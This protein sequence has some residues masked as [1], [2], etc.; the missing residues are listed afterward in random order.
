M[1]ESKAKSSVDD[2]V[3]PIDLGKKKGESADTRKS[4][5][6]E[7]KKSGTDKTKRAVALPQRESDSSV[8]KRPAARAAKVTVSE[9]KANSSDGASKEK[10]PTSKPTKK[11]SSGAKAKQSASSGA[12]KG[13]RSQAK[14]RE[15]EVLA[16]KAKSARPRYAF[17]VPRF[18]RSGSQSEAYAVSVVHEL[19][20]RGNEVLVV[21]GNGGESEDEHVTV[22]R[23]NPLIMGRK[24]IKTFKPRH[25]IDWGY[26]IPAEFRHVDSPYE[27]DLRHGIG[28]CKGLT[29]LIKHIQFRFSRQHRSRIHKQRALMRVS[30]AQF[31]AQSDLVAEDLQGA[32]VDAARIH[33][34]PY[35]VDLDRFSP[36][37]NGTAAK[38]F[39]A[40]HGFTDDEVIFLC[41][42][43]D[44]DLV[45]IQS[46]RAVFTL[47]HQKNPHVRLLHMGTVDPGWKDTWF[48]HISRPEQP[49]AVYAAAD[50][51]VHPAVHDSAAP[52]VIQAMA[53]ALPVV[54]TDNIGS[55][56]FVKDSGGALFVPSRGA[57]SEKSWIEAVEQLADNAAKRKQLGQA[58]R[59]A[60][61]QR[62]LT[63]FVD[64]LEIILNRSPQS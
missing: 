27:Q 19:A 15:S 14:K 44:P 17:V 32:G 3:K 34:L 45:D 61:A 46:L 50:A 55:L 2:T 29:R 54:T 49:E 5:S 42:T 43:D 48:V 62:T 10:A 20:R 52:V 58:G 47:V 41:V 37:N 6:S 16:E 23:A 59:N 57:Q 18:S 21:T 64:Q 63:N 9:D 38:S 51:L 39:R 25:I 30:K 26:N 60:A 11:S 28:A 8:S 35:G 56:Q 12:S 24:A 4:A 22:R 36:D 33:V 13:K 40:E 31:L 7:A 53:A 1:S